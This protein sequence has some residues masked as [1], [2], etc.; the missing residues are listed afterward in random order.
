MRE[1]KQCLRTLGCY[2]ARAGKHEI[3]KTADGVQ[4]PAL[5]HPRHDNDVILVKTQKQFWL[6]RG[7]DI[8]LVEY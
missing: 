7:I 4:I 6:T 2:Q 3:W 5:P 8:D 1:L